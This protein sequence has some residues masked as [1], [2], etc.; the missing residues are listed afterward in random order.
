MLPAL[1]GLDRA[2]RQIRVSRGRRHVNL[3]TFASFATLWLMPRLAGF[4]Q[5]H[6]DIDLRISA[7]DVLADLDDPELTWPCATTL[8]PM[9]RPR[10]S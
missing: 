2:V 1:D 10:P 6:P 7:T 5:Q 4:Q 3:S 8:P 9:Y